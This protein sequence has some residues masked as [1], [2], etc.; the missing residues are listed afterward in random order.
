MLLS[1]DPMR[2]KTLLSIA[3]AAMLMVQVSCVSLHWRN[4][5]SRN[6]D[7]AALLGTARLIHDGGMPDYKPTHLGVDRDAPEQPAARPA[8]APMSD[9]LHPPFE[10]FLF[11]PLTPFSY[12]TA[13]ILWTILNLVL[14]WM[15]P[16]VLWTF[17]PRLHSMAHI[18]A[19]VYGKFFCFV[20][21]Q[22]QTV[23]RRVLPRA[24]SVQISSGAPGL[25]GSDCDALLESH[26]WIR[27]RHTRAST[28]NDG[29]DRT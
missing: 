10:A 6:V 13:F 4:I 19:M 22:R 17:L 11:L 16:A 28:R 24:G 25:R 14:L 12:T 1:R 15:V 5:Q 18:L 2:N 21:T 3:V 7:F 27:L 23:S 29:D 8:N 9:S 20:L 26:C